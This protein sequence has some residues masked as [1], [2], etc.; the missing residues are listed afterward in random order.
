MFGKLKTTFHINQQGV[1][2]GLQI[3]KKICEHLQ[4][5]IE[6]K[7]KLNEG[8]VFSIKVLLS[9]VKMPRSI[10]L[11]RNLSYDGQLERVHQRSISVPSYMEG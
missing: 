6:V 3:T 8:S 5:N 9:G 11:I 1:G 7:S 2:L 10:P 4:G